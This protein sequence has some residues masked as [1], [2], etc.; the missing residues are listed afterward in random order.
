M[1]ALVAGGAGLIG[2]HLCAR[3][4]EE[5]YEVICLDSFIT[6]SE[7]NL[8]A[9]CDDPA[10]ML[11]RGDVTEV[12]ELDVD[13]IFHLASPASPIGYWTHPFETIRANTEGTHRLLDLAR[14]YGARFLF[15][16]T[17]EVYGDPLI[18]PQCED[19]WGNVNSIGI[20]ACYDE[21]K[22][23]GETITMEYVRQLGV[24]ARIVRIFN[25]YGPHNH[26]NDGRMIPNFIRQALIGA[27]ITIHGDGMQTRSICY[28]SDLVE[29][30]V[31][32]MFREN[33]RGEVINLG[34]PDERT[35]RQ[36][37]EL[38]ISICGSS[39]PLVM[40]AARSD[41]PERRC[42]NIQKAARLLSWRPTVPPE[43]GLLR[44]VEWFREQLEYAPSHIAASVSET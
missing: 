37:A 39:S 43:E 34:N 23:L 27:S 12:P 41:D 30:L 10:F 17:S 38:V 21:S 11:M 2:S 1:R 36:W 9:V 42:P 15:A 32:M 26:P 14:R 8:E 3:L 28:V 16:S 44:T 6:G 33:T 25:T 31:R 7:R 5:G 20:R 4:L 13:V 22:R 24:D 18:H 19:Y 29:G 40:G 35:V